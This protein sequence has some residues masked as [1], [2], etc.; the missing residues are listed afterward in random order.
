[1]H[2]TYDPRSALAAAGTSS[3][4]TTSD[5]PTRPPGAS[6]RNISAKT[7]DLSTARLITQFEIT[8]STD[9]SDSGKSSMVP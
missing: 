4:A 8:T 9:P 1:M 6:T 3:W 5:T 2:P 7:A